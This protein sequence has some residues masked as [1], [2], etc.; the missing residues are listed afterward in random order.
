METGVTTEDTMSEP[1]VSQVET[2]VESQVDCIES[3]EECNESASTSDETIMTSRLLPVDDNDQSPT[4][5]T[6]IYP[7][8]EDDRVAVTSPI[9][10]SVIESTD[11]VAHTSCSKDDLSAERDMTSRATKI[12]KYA[13]IDRSDVEMEDD[14]TDSAADNFKELHVVRKANNRKVSTKK[15]TFSFTGKLSFDR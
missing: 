3:V 15:R 10:T 6:E 1:E 14:V 11:D 2:T 12:D 7:H 13:G 9:S 8:F 5:T 4:T